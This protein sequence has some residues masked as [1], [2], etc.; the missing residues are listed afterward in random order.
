M[1]KNS[2][3]P[4]TEGMEMAQESW[5][6][7]RLQ[8]VVQF[9]LR[10]TLRY[11]IVGAENIPADGAILAV[12]HRSLADAPIVMAALDRPVTFM[13]TAGLFRVPILG[14]YLWLMGHIPVYRHAHRR[15]ANATETTLS[16]AINKVQSGA[17]VCI[18]P[19]GYI[20]TSDKPHQIKSGIVTLARHGC[21][22]VPVVMEGSRQIIGAKIRW[23]RLRRHVTITVHPPLGTT[24]NAEIRAALTK[25]FVDT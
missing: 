21:P 13:A 17:L 8:K 5:F 6:K 23:P 14:Q 11:T 18:F 2:W 12:N 15:P 16:A 25:L 10:R 20:V 22:V 19:E 9:F 7:L 3:P 4:E 1:L 24:D